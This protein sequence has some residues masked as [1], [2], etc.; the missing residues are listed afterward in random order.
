MWRTSAGWVVALLSF[1]LLAQAQA[2]D[3]RI[4]QLEKETAQ[5]KATVAEQGHRI[6]E[7]ESALKTLQAVLKPTP[8]PIPGPTPPWFE[9][10]NWIKLSPGMSEEEVVAILGPPSSA[11]GKIDVRTLVYETGPSETRSLKGSVTLTDD[12]LTGAQPPKF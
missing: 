10:S 11:D 4:D 7:L 8:K 12:R 3:P 5:L 1:P 9:P 2:H 6:A